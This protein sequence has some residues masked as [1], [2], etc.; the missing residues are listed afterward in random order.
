[1]LTAFTCAKMR[2]LG[3]APKAPDRVPYPWGGGGQGRRGGGRHHISHTQEGME[4]VSY[5]S[6]AVNQCARGSCK[7]GAFICL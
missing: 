2:L 3:P 4:Y 5:G 7:A 1:M 6:E